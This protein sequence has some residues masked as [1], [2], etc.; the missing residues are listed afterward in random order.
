[1]WKKAGCSQIQ[2]SILGG[3]ESTQIQNESI[4][5]RQAT[6]AFLQTVIKIP[7]VKDWPTKPTLTQWRNV[8][9]DL[10]VGLRSGNGMAFIDCDDKEVPGTSENVFNWLAGLGYNRGDYPIVQTA[11]GVGHHVYV[12]FTET[13]PKSRSNLVQS[14]GAGDFRYGSGSYVEPSPQQSKIL[15]VTN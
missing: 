6:I 9:E 1:M 11:S 4:S 15:A 12:N 2:P 10:N 5:L 3:R 8:T 13:L 14:M 7:L